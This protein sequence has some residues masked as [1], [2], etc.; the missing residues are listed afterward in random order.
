LYFVR[1][2]TR[3]VVGVFVRFRAPLPS[4]SLLPNLSLFEPVEAAVGH[5]LPA[6]MCWA[7]DDLHSCGC[8]VLVASA[9]ERQLGILD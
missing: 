4:V 2:L 3:E 8:C 6:R 1:L 5:C 7:N 9:L